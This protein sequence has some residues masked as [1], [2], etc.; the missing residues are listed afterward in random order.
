VSIVEIAAKMREEWSMRPKQTWESIY[1]TFT[2]RPT[3]H[4]LYVIRVRCSGVRCLSV[5]PPSSAQRRSTQR[6]LGTFM[7]KL[8]LNS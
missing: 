2:A 4:G 3:K 6:Y 8:A 7:R 1:V 5:D